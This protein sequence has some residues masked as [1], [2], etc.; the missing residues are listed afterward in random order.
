[1]VS[2]NCDIPLSNLPKP[3]LKG[4]KIFIKISKDEYQLSLKSCTNNLYVKLSLPKGSSPLK[5]TKL[6][7]KL[8]K[9]WSP[10]THWKIVI[11]YFAFSFVTLKDLQS[12]WSA[13][14]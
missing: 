8:L 12:I 11:G 7:E 5:T 10:M 6:Y 4:D 1:M 13:G 2:N 14:T 9:L 3:C